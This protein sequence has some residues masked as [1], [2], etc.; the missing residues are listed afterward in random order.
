LTSFEPTLVELERLA[1][2]YA[3]L[4]DLRR[5][6]AAGAKPPENAELRALAKAFPGALRELDQLTEDEIGRRERALRLAAKTA[7]LEPW[8]RW[9]HGYHGV[10]RAGLYIKVRSKAAPEESAVE[11]A[12]RASTHAGYPVDATF[13]SMLR[14]RGRCRVTVVALEVLAE[15]FGIDFSTLRATLLPRAS[16]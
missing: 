15:R 3:T 8:M 4:A 12:A 11:L 10:L 14:E 13:V 6:H 1:D 16:R 9:I 7:N 2:K 5:K